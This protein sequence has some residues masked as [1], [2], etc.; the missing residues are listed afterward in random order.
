MAQ[1]LQTHDKGAY[2]RLLEA[3]Y[4]L[5]SKEDTALKSIVYQFPHLF[6]WCQ[7]SYDKALASRN[8]LAQGLL[9]LIRQ[10]HGSNA[11]PTWHLAQSTTDEVSVSRTC[12]S[13]MLVPDIAYCVSILSHCMSMC[14]G[15][16]LC[17]V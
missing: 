9:N 3:L 13:C 4:E 10:K 17:P 14:M 2:Q 6:T 11:M 15:H 16:M 8:E 5:M 1:D 7:D 12:N